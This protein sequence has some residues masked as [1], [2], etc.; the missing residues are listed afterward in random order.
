MRVGAVTIITQT[1]KMSRLKKIISVM[2][3]YP[4]CMRDILDNLSPDDIAILKG[5]KLIKSYSGRYV[6][7]SKT[8][9]GRILRVYYRRAVIRQSERKRYYNG[10]LPNYKRFYPYK[11]CVQDLPFEKVKEKV[12]NYLQKYKEK[13]FLSRYRISQYLKVVQ[14]F[15]NTVKNEFLKIRN[16]FSEL[17]ISS[18]KKIFDYFSGNFD[19]IKTY[20]QEVNLSP[21]LCGEIPHKRFYATI[22]WLATPK[23]LE[24]VPQGFYRLRVYDSLEEP[25]VSLGYPDIVVNGIVYTYDIF[26]G[27]YRRKE[28]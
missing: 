10:T 13:Y 6:L 19:S 14:I 27:Q 28:V 24:R 12:F 3:R 23:A 9:I 21:F 5:F 15:N 25:C 22:F 4:H 1:K 18:A 7:S 16:R 26:T 17:V 8:A 20:F 2:L 11:K